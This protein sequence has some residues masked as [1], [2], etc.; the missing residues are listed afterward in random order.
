MATLGSAV[1]VAGESL[2]RSAEIWPDNNGVHINAH[3]GGVIVHEGRFWWYG[4]HKIDGK[5]GNNAH[6]A[7]VHVY[8][9]KD[10]V[11]WQ[12]EG[13]ALTC[14]ADHE[15]PIADGSVIE[16]P[17]VV[18]C[19]KTGK[20]VM[21][22]H[23][24]LRGKGYTA[25]HLGVAI[26]DRPQGPFKLVRSE[27]P[28]KGLLPEGFNASSLSADDKA[29]AEKFAAI[30]NPWDP[31]VH[32]ELS[33]FPYTFY[34]MLK[35]GQMSQDQTVFIDDD[36]KAYHICASEYD[37][38]LHFTEL[39]DDY[40]HS[41]GKWWRV[42]INDYTEAPAVCKRGEWYYLIGSGCTGWKPNKARLYRA[43][44]L[45][46]P[47]ERLGNPCEGTNTVTGQS[48]DLTW[49]GQSTFIL[50]LPGKDRYI[51]M[52]DIWRPEN[53]IDGRYVWLPIEFKEDS[54]T[55]PWKAAWSIGEP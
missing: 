50:K 33:K 41:S 13:A 44:N 37:A 7:A 16:R 49:G 40:L 17:K 9:S 6:G 29:K 55:I 31:A 18:Y 32:P 53:A 15:S 42:A 22:F 25:A 1:V 14:S 30:S 26:A 19:K 20:F 21:Y 5:A 51:A 4:E 38:T 34:G 36:G 27:R 3:G 12:D 8:S 2:V 10:L 23:N 45:R 11:H 24:E 52:F 48:A 43:K 39:T 54:L 47:W 46:G 28:N 35:T